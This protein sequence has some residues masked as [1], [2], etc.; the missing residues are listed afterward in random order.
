MN[1]DKMN[2]LWSTNIR[3][4][5]PN[6]RVS[7]HMKGQEFFCGVDIVYFGAGLL[8]LIAFLLMTRSEEL[9][10]MVIVYVNLD[11]HIKNS[12]LARYC[13]S[14]QSTQKLRKS[15]NTTERSINPQCL[16]LQ[17]RK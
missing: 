9:S 5:S 10:M 14:T 16:N 8:V 13:A 12:F 3:T 6:K 11:L 4:W 1:F 17:T 2:H 15:Y 7:I